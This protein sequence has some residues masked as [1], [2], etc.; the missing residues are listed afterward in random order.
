M[1]Q[2]VHVEKLKHALGMS[3]LL[4]GDAAVGERGVEGILVRQGGGV[5][6]LLERIPVF[7]G[8]HPLDF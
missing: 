6:P 2:M 4:V 5:E 8:K 7:V 1:A 3:I